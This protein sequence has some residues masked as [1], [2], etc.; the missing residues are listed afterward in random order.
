MAAAI[1]AGLPVSEPTGNMIV[2]IGGG[3]TEVAV[4]SLGGIVVSQ[5]IRV[6]GDELDEAIV[7]YVKREYKLLIGTQTSEEVKLEIGSAAPMKEELQAEIRGRDL[8]TGLPK[9]VVLTLAGG[10]A[11]ARGAAAADRRRDQ[12]DA[13]QDAARAR[14]RHH[15]PRHHARR[16]RRAPAPARRAD[17][18]RDRDARAHRRVAAD[19]RRGRLRPLARGVRDDEPREP[20]PQ[21][22]TPGTAAAATRSRGRSRAQTHRIQW[23]STGEAGAGL[24]AGARLPP[25]ERLHHDGL[26]IGASFEFFPPKTPELAARLQE[27]AELLRPLE[28]EFVSVTFG[29]GGSTRERTV[30]TVLDLAPPRLHRRPPT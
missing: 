14:L 18:P 26:R 23:G 24:V 28:P 22:R 7:N 10:A 3:T 29:A 1:G 6:G 12:V 16:R 8:V 15:G 13:R 9:T 27:T 17:P 4:I 21:R 20:R 5:S 11:R 19:L 30:E 2:D 25:I